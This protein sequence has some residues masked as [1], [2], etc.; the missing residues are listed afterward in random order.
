[1]Q[2]FSGLVEAVSG[3]YASLQWHIWLRMTY[4]KETTLT[5]PALAKQHKS[6]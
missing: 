1:M 5:N 2:T 4:G 6:Y 3:L